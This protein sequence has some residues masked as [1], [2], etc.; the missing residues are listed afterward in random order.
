MKTKCYS[1]RLE[2]MTPISSKCWKAQAF[3]GSEALIPA[4]QVFGQDYDVM[5]SEAW[6][7]SAWILEKKEIQYSQKKEAW[8]DSDTGRMMPTYKV[9]KHVPQKISPKEIKA[10][11]TLTR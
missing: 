8:F 1:V 4:S 2:S 9:E 10:D 3:D 6:W 11:E 5:K 7:I